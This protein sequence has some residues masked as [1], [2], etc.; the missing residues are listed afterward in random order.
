MTQI[1]PGVVAEVFDRSGLQ[2][3][4]ITNVNNGEVSGF[5]VRNYEFS[6]V[7][8]EWSGSMD[9]II[10]VTSPERGA[11][12]FYPEEEQWVS[13][14]TGGERLFVRSSENHGKYVKNTGEAMRVIVNTLFEIGQ[15]EEAR[16]MK[17]NLDIYKSFLEEMIN[18]SA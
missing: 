7:L 2:N 12:L 9:E 16:N 5:I 1:T 18:P 10:S 4:I 3:A 15:R 17:Q 6:D 8:R 13:I 14:T 11:V